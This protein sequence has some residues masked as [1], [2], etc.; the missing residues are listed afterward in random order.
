MVILAY[1]DLHQSADRSKS[2]TCIGYSSLRDLEKDEYRN[3]KG[4]L[5]GGDLLTFQKAIERS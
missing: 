5:L 2:L 3:W 1:Q 4:A